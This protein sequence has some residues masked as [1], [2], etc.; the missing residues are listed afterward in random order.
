MQKNAVPP[1][2]DAVFDKFLSGIEYCRNFGA[3]ATSRYAAHKAAKALVA[4]QHA[5]PW[6]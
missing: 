3:T 5:G 2:S 4:T 6:D 1:A